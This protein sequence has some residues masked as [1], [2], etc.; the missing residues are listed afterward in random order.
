VN[1]SVNTGS[2]STSTSRG[3]HSVPRPV[4]ERRPHPPAV[5][6]G[7][8]EASEDRSLFHCAMFLDG[9]DMLNEGV[10][11]LGLGAHRQRRL[12]EGVHQMVHLAE[13]QS[14][15]TVPPRACPDAAACPPEPGMIFRVRRTGSAER[16]SNGARDLVSLHRHPHVGIRSLD[17]R[18]D[19]PPSLGNRA[20][21]RP[22]RTRRR[23]HV[24]S[25]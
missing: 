11:R 9:A 15:G 6:G 8:S 12:V 20:W 18:L 4:L 17:G 25:R 23:W 7:A 5:R 13:Q 1:Y 14:A 21:A 22:A 19:F 2:R 10:T 16:S 24:V 3:R